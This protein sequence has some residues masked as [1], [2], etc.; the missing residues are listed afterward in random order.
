[1][2]KSQGPDLKKY[3]D[4]RMKVLLNGKREVNGV[5]RGFDQFMNLVLD[6]AQEVVSAKEKNDIGVVVIRGNSIIQMELLEVSSM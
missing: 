4:Q 2:P 1:M 6:D 5:L 3:M